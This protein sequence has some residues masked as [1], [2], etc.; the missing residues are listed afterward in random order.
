VKAPRAGTRVAALA[1]VVLAGCSNSSGQKAAGTTTTTTAGHAGTGGAT[2]GGGGHGGGTATGGG[3]GQSTH[4]GGTG[5]G[6]AG[7]TAGSGGAGGANAGGHGAGGADAGPSCLHCS[8]A[9]S[10][11][12]ADP[13]TYCAGT[14]TK[15]DALHVCICQTKCAAVC[16]DNACAKKDQSPDCA[17]CIPSSCQTE[18]FACMNDS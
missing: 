3:G 8:Q 4:A 9:L 12:N 11:P 6:G 5:H 1:L 18:Y 17:S 14:A 7:G 13:S 15:L 2:G 16:G 10:S